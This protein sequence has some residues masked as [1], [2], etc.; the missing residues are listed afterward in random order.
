MKYPALARAPGRA[1]RSRRRLATALVLA[2]IGGTLVAAPVAAAPQVRTVDRT[3]QFGPTDIGGKIY[4]VV[5]VIN[6]DITVTAE[7]TVTQP[8][9]ETFDYD[10]GQIR[11]GQTV[12]VARS[13]AANGPGNLHVVWHISTDLP[14]IAGTFDTSRN[15]SC[16]ISFVNPVNCHAES[17][18]FPLTP[19]GTLTPGVPYA[20]LVLQAEVTVTPDDANVDSTELAGLVTIGGP[21]SQAEPGT[22]DVT[23]PCNVG[24]GSTLS[25]SDANYNLASHVN[26]SDG[27]AITVGVW[28]PNPITVVP[29][30]KSPGVLLD[31]GSQHTE[32]FAQDV[33]DATTKVTALGQIAANNVP[34][35]ADAG[36]PYEDKLEG[37]PVQFNGT[38]TTSICGLD[39]LA[40]RWDFSDGGVAFGQQPFHTFQDDGIFSGLLTAT[41]P[42]GLSNSV[43]FSVEVLNQ[44]PAANAG[45]DTQADWG[46]LVA[47]NGQA[48]DPGED[49]QPFLEYSWDFGDGTPPTNPSAGGANA[50]H[51]YATPG[52]Y[53]ATLT[54]TDDDGGSDTDTRDVHVTKRDVT[55]AYLGPTA[56]TYDTATSFSGSLVDEYGQNVGGRTLRFAVDSVAQAQSATNS[57]GFASPNWTPLLDA[58]FYTTEAI[59]LGDSLYNADTGD[60]TVTIARK[61]TSVTYTGALNGGPN[62]TIGLSAILADA[63]G[64]RLG[65]RTIVF[66]LGSQTTS[67]ATNANGVAT[68]TLTLNQK[69][70]IYPLTATF[71]PGGGD[72]VKYLSSSDA[73]SFKLQ[74]K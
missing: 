49:D 63:D 54:V 13:V 53:T 60:G 62:K 58:G 9:R 3:I 40:L 45:P 30:F 23:I 31:L 15:A 57:S 37:I 2:A 12:P 25:L 42:T 39:S 29:A 33:S 38:G 48:T 18:G 36:G 26:S 6:G 21:S 56:A 17:I 14:L 64:T 22:Q 52:D 43:A 72:A 55:A 47:F 1:G 68:T 7:V 27:P 24:V 51:A 41:D 8:I 70:G 74:K 5:G 10:D 4:H 34:P 71:T 35:D 69:N 59:F 66:V 19:D 44:D 11:Q 46:R 67:A 73:E 32:S 50:V 20:D 28:V 61:A 65:G 16:T